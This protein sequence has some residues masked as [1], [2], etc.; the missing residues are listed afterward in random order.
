[1]TSKNTMETGTTSYLD[2]SNLAKRF[3]ENLEEFL[4]DYSFRVIPFGHNVILKG[5][6]WI[7]SRLRKLDSKSSTEALMIKF[8]PDYIIIKESSPKDLFFSDA[9]ASITPVFFQAQIDR[10]KAHYKKD[11]NLKRSDVGEIEREAWLSY[12]TFYPQVVII[13]ASPYNPSLIKAEWAK[14]VECMWCFKESSEET[15]PIPWDCKKCPIKGNEKDN[16]GVVVN[17]FA[18]GSGT[19]HVNIHLGKMRNLD[20]F[21][22]QEFGIKI[23]KTEYDLTMLNFIKKWPLNKPAGRVTWGQYNG[24]IRTLQQEGCSWLKYRYKDQLCNTWDEWKALAEAEGSR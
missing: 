20:D 18:G 15:G 19:P 1:M 21:L 22:I 3:E 7:E 2:R 16:F 5:N 17:K 8:S 13:I 4:K 10:I 6:T 23:D 11:P 24:A 14:N 12:N 9:K